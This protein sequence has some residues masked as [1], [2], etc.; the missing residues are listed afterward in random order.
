[1]AMVFMPCTYM[2]FYLHMQDT[3]DFIEEVKPTAG[4]VFLVCMVCER[5]KKEFGS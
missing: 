4:G 3:Q 1:M 2:S 5:G